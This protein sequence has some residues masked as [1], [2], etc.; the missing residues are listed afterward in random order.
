MAP[1]ETFHFRSFYMPP[2][3]ETRIM[4]FYL[5]DRRAVLGKRLHSDAHSRYS[6]VVHLNAGSPNSGNGIQST[7]EPT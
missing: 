5:R 7:R 6:Y 2:G 3:I 1:A 4:S